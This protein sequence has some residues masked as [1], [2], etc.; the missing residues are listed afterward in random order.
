MLDRRKLLDN[1]YILEIREIGRLMNIPKLTTRHID[2]DWF[3]HHLDSSD[4]ALLNVALYTDV[5]PQG[6]PTLICP[7]ALP[8]VLKWMYDH[9][10]G[11][12]SNEVLSDLMKDIPEDEYVYVSSQGD[13][14]S[15]VA[16]WK[17]WRRVSRTSHDGNAFLS[18]P[19]TASLTVNPGITYASSERSV[20]PHPL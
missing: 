7:A 3:D 13:H 10:E 11:G 20:I 6:G 14:C 18:I 8:K 16:L 5:L 15:C 9:P 1:M 12:Y 19:L 2:G 17:S 4:Q